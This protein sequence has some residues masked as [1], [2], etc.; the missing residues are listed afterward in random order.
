M[1]RRLIWL[2]AGGSIALVLA[3]AAGA[4]GSATGPRSLKPTVGGTLTFG[5]EQEPPGLNIVLT[6]CTAFWGQVTAITPVLK[7]AFQQQPDLSYKEDLVTKVDEVRK[8]FTL[9]YHIKPEAKWSDGTPVSA[10]DFI[11]TW[12][13]YIN[14]AWDVANRT[15][16]LSI[17]RAKAIDQKTVRFFFKEPFAGWRANIFTNT[18]PVLPKHALQ[19]EDFNKVWLNAIAN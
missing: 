13:T 19:G 14:K 18:S 6:C 15:G 16:Y 10:Q 1:R 7:G 8:P 17:Y 9:T 3:A 2:L 4:G 11:F 12:Q 5:A